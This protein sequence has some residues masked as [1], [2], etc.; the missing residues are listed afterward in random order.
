MTDVKTDGQLQVRS[1]SNYYVPGE[2][3][4]HYKGGVYQLVTLAVKEDTGTIMVVYKSLKHSTV[5]TRTLNNWCE[6]VELP[7]GK[8]KRFIRGAP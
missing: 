2:Y 6:E 4:T 1:L 8:V 5:W 7:T 3:W